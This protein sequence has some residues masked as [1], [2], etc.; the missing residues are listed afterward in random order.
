MTNPTTDLLRV[1]ELVEKVA[2]GPITTEGSYC[3]DGEQVFFASATDF[4]DATAIAAAVNF[5]REHGRTLLEALRDAERL[6]YIERTYSGVTNRER[7]LPVQMGWGNGSN[8]RTLR[9]ACDKYMAR[10]AYRK[11]QLTHAA[12]SGGLTV[13]TEEVRIPENGDERG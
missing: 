7:Y 9:E 8:G 11:Q 4:E 1:V 12:G 5:L 10:D 2:P 6:D 13:E 3:L